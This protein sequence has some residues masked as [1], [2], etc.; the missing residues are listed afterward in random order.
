M[1]NTITKQTI[2][3]GSKNLVVKIHISGDGS[4]EETDTVLIDAS[5]YSPAFIDANLIGVH[6]ALSGFSANLQWDA[7]A[8]VPLINLPDYEYNLDGKQIGWFGGIPND[9]G[10]G[11]T[12]DILITTSGLGAGDIGTII[13]ELK[14]KV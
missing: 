13:L 8:N 12:G 2:I 1:A 14:K 3:D 9:S 11:K 10:A 5:S 6:G 7:T 4:G